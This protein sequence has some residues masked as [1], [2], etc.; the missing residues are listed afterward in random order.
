MLFEKTTYSDD[1]PI[2]I[3]IANITEYPLHYHQDI[4]FVC[5]L[6]GEITLKNGC[7][8]YSLKSGDIFTNSGHEVHGMASSDPD[9]VVALIQIS[10]RYFSQ[11]FPTL[12]KSCYRTYSNKSK[13]KKHDKLQEMILAI[14]LQ[15]SIKSPKYKT[16]CIYAMIDVISYLEKVFNLFAFN[17]KTIVNFEN[18]N[19]IT[20]D[21]ISRIT[22]YIYEHYSEKITL[23]ELC[24][25]EHLSKFYLSHIIKNYT[26]MNFREFLCFARV[27]WSEIPLLDSNKKISQIARDVG[28]STTSYYESYFEKWFGHSPAAHRQMYLSKVLSDS[29]GASLVA[30][31]A[32]KAAH[33]LKELISAL[34]SQKDSTSLVNTL[35]LEVENDVATAPICQLAHKLN[36]YVTLE[37]FQ[38]LGYS[39]FSLIADLRPSLVTVLADDI[40]D[41]KVAHLVELLSDA[42]FVVESKPRQGFDMSAFSATTDSMALPIYLIQKWINQSEEWI[43]LPLREQSPNDTMASRPSALTYAGVKRPSYF[44]FQLLSLINGQLIGMGTRYRIVSADIAD[45]P[46]YL[47]FA[48]NYNEEI[49]DMCTKKTTLLGERSILD[50]FV[51][52]LDLNVSLAMPT[53]TYTITKCTI[54]NNPTYYSLLTSIDS[55]TKTEKVRRWSMLVPTEPELDYFTEYVNKAIN[56]NFSIKGAGVQI[57]IIQP[58][59]NMMDL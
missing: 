9:N 27:E 14:L 36:I 30:I 41:K 47:I 22:R 45:R 19:Q 6:K 42:G 31:P 21:R 59:P 40:L 26:G 17:G 55:A 25:M 11:Y 18:N 13:S 5:V 52:E 49:F 4:E 12:S 46:S 1:F 33:L 29:H 20:I 24:E 54:I 10:N 50:S 57:A 32:G 23:D 3:T 39:I 38:V 51:D 16:E 37:D 28:F 7:C 43:H 56:L 44:V 53:G 2:N 58:S 34:S 35:R 48:T 8:T 15:Y